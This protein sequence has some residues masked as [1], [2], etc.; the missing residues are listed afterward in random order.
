MKKLPFDREGEAI[1]AAVGALAASLRIRVNA[2]GVETREQADCVEC[3]GVAEGQ[4]YLFGKPCPNSEFV[5]L[6]T[7]SRKK[8]PGAT[9]PLELTRV[10]A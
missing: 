10:V 2:E 5:A 8:W 9:P 3:L 1:V 4:G 7:T 6:L